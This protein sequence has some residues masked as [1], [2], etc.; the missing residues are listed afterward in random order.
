MM[1]AGTQSVHGDELLSKLHHLLVPNTLILSTNSV[2]D[3]ASPFILVLLSSYCTAYVNKVYNLV[4]SFKVPLLLKL[5]RLA[6]ESD[7]FSIL[8]CKWFSVLVSSPN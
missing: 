1:H 2:S 6:A 5:K 8:L 7:Y 4:F 3:E